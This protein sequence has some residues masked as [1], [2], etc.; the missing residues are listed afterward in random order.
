MFGSMVSASGRSGASSGDAYQVIA[1]LTSGGSKVGGVR[2]RWEL[3]R[4]WGRGGQGCVAI[5]SVA[6]RLLDRTDLI[7]LL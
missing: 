6:A 4:N 7:L 1:E 3:A 2:R 5:D